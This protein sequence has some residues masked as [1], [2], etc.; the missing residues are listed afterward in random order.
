MKSWFHLEEAEQ[1]G[2]QCP[3]VDVTG[4][5]RRVWCCKQQYCIG[6][7]NVKSMCLVTQSCLTLCDPMDYSLTCS[8]VQRDSPGKNTGVCCHALFR[9][10]FPTQGLN[11]SLLHSRQILYCLS[12]QGS[13]ASQIITIKWKTVPWLF[14]DKSWF[15]FKNSINYSKTKICFVKH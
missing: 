6:T 1:K 10:L 5:V 8:S 11:P 7:R 9:G 13:L 4:D 3:I 14:V 15:Q 12:H 2:K